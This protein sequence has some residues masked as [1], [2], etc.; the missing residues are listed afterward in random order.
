MWIFRPISLFNPSSQNTVTEVCKK[1]NQ[2]AASFLGPSARSLLIYAN[3]LRLEFISVVKSFLH[4]AASYWTPNM[5]K[6]AWWVESWQ[7]SP[8]NL[9]T[10]QTLWDQHLGAKPLRKSLES[11]LINKTH[12][13]M[14]CPECLESNE[15]FLRFLHKTSIFQVSRWRN[16]GAAWPS[17]TCAVKQQALDKYWHA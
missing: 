15:K 8:R 4:F 1:P 9:R 10:W 16:T 17:A 7:Y 3:L 11:D 6:A 5:P 12:G 14:E 13:C 2:K